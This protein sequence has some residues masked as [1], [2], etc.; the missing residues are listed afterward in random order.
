MSLEHSEVSVKHKSK[1]IPFVVDEE[2]D[3]SMTDTSE[4]N[5]VDANDVDTIN[6]DD[7]I[8]IDEEGDEKIIQRVNYLRNTLQLEKSYINLLL[9]QTK[10]QRLIYNLTC[11]VKQFSFQCRASSSHDEDIDILKKNYEVKMDKCKVL[12][13]KCIEQAKISYVESKTYT[14]SRQNA[15]PD[16]E[17]LAQYYKDTFDYI[18]RTNQYIIRLIEDD[19]KAV[20]YNI[21]QMFEKRLKTLQLRSK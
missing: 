19:Y 4:Y 10:L 5:G 16:R 8:N 9:N 12:Y 18:E 15:D 13:T 11:C 2:D 14:I 20:Q 3:V 21:K 7:T 1:K 17:K 6:V